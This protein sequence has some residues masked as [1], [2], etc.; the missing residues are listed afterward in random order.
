MP[1]PKPAALH[2]QKS[3]SFSKKRPNGFLTI[4]NIVT[5]VHNIDD[6]VNKLSVNEQLYYHYKGGSMLSNPDYS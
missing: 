2:G 4:I 1:M 6:I 3:L 5:I